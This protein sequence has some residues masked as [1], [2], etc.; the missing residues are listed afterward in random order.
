MDSDRHGRFD[1]SLVAATLDHELKIVDDAVNAVASGAFR[2]VTVAGLRFGEELL[3]R[4]RALAGRHD[5][6]IRPLFA[7][8]EHGADLIVERRSGADAT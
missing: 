4:A 6:R 8:D 3:P 7:A 2:S 1:A 5:L